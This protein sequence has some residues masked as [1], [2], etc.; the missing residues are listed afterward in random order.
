M[1]SAKEIKML[2]SGKGYFTA[3]DVVEALA[4]EGVE[5]SP[6]TYRNKENGKYSFAAKE[7]RALSHVFGLSIGEAMDIF[8]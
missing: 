2:R 3:K 7:V 4:K 8:S 6:S 1:R 5:M